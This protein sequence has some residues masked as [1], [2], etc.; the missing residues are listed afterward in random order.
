MLLTSNI[1]GA[2]LLALE[3]QLAFWAFGGIDHGCSSKEGGF[4]C[5][6]Q[7]LFNENF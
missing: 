1:I 3:G 7:P 2:L 5:A 6:T 4:P